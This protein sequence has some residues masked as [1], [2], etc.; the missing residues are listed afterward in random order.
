MAQKALATEPRVAPVREAEYTTI[1]GRTLDPVYSRKD[2]EGLPV[3]DMPGEYPYTRGVHPTMYRG[4]LWTMRQFAGF[5]TPEET[6]A[7]FRYLLEQD[8]KSVV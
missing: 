4:K 2:L 6:N 7:R 5:S 3:E 1:S 8:R